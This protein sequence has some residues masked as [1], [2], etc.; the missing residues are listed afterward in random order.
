MADVGERFRQLDRLV[1]PNQWR[2][3][4]TRV[5]AEIEEPRPWR[6]VGVALL[7]LAV[8]AAG[9]LVAVHALGGTKRTTL[10]P[11]PIVPK[12]NGKIAFIAGSAPGS[13]FVPSSIYVMDPDGTHVQR[14]TKTDSREGALAW[15]PDGS[16]LAFLRSGGE[17]PPVNLFVMNADGSDLQQ[18]THVNQYQGSPTWSP[19]GSHIA[20]SRRI[21]DYNFNIYVMKADG[22]DVVEITHDAV[23][24]ITPSWSPDGTRIAFSAT[25]QDVTSYHL[26]VMQSDGSRVRQLTQGK[27]D[28]DPMWSPDGRQIVFL[29]DDGVYLVNEDGSNLHKVFGCLCQSATWSPDGREILVSQS[30]EGALTQ[31]ENT[32]ALFVMDADGTNVRR[33]GPARL[34]ACCA[35]WQPIPVEGSPPHE[36]QSLPGNGEI[37]FF[38]GG[39]DGPSAIYGVEPD[40]SNETLLWADGRDPTVPQ[41]KIHPELVSDAFDWSPDGSKLVIM[42]YAPLSGGGDYDVFVMVADGAKLTRL[43]DDHAI[44]SQPSWSPDGSRIAYAVARGGELMIPGCWG[45]HLCP[46]DIYVMNADGSGQTRLTSESEDDSQP[47]WSPDGTQI[48]FRSERD[49]PGGD[50]YVMNAD[51]TDVTRLATGLEG[52]HRPR[53]SPDGS[54]IAFIGSDGS[55]SHAYLI[56]IDG[57]GLTRIDPFNDMSG[58]GDV[59]WSP[60]GSTLAFTTDHPGG[61]ARE[62]NLFVIDVEGGNVTQLTTDGAGGLAWRPIPTGS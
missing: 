24:E 32:S 4:E 52:V 44:D 40:G 37:W 31:V 33:V 47:D 17:F 22:S 13:V 34:S 3:I 12:A 56:N 7:A 49:A 11:I 42:H 39:G 15:S 29:R 25:A 55:K 28:R 2:D 8:A 41:G 5:P 48:V 43:T 6:R 51:G 35:A 57:T 59:V 50:L 1:A 21:G 36:V 26:Y 23:K 62:F 54:S 58:V 20:F 14:L 30:D 19:D 9:T 61:A 38:R 60:D 53:W 45:S 16:K 18:I 46:S 27:V 10:H